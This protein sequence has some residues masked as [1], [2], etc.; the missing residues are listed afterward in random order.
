[1]SRIGGGMAMIFRASEVVGGDWGLAVGVSGSGGRMIRRLVVMDDRNRV[2]SMKLGWV[3]G[4][5]WEWRQE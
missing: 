2:V 4:E 5:C 3:L 1:M